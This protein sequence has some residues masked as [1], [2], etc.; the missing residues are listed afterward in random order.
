MRIILV[1]LLALLFF[2]GCM[3]KKWITPLFRAETVK[4]PEP[5]P[6]TT[7]AKLTPKPVDQAK[8]GF[9][10]NVQITNLL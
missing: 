1:F 9:P 8:N 2:P 4:F 3:A 10:R 6:P 7:V 5:D